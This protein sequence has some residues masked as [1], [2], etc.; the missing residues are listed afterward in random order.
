MIDQEKKEV[1]TETLET[2]RTNLMKINILR[3]LLNKPQLKLKPPLSLLLRSH[4]NLKNLRNLLL[5]STTRT[6]V[7]SSTITSTEKLQWRKLR[8]MRIGSRRKSLSF[9]RL[10]KRRRTTRETHKEQSNSQTAEAESK[11][12]FRS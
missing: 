1:D 10:N 6:K 3:R 7:L 2:L 4:Q 11:K 8:S 9:W 12:I 5:K